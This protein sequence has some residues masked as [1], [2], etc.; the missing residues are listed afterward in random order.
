MAKSQLLAEKSTEND[1]F[2]KRIANIKL[3]SLLDI[4]KAINNNLST[5]RLF[6]LYE[7][8]LINELNIGKIALFTYNNNWK[9]VL[10]HGIENEF[11]DI[12]IEIDLL[13]YK[14]IT[15]IDVVAS[16]SA[17]METF[18]IIIPVYHKSQ[19]LAYLLIGDL[20]EQKI[21]MSPTIKHLPFVQTLTNIIMVAIENKRLARENLSQVASRK[22]LELAS[23][24]QA[25]L[26]P[27]KLPDDDNLNIH[28]YYQPHHQVG[29]DYY[30]FIKLNEN[31]VAFCVADVSGKGVSAALLMANF[32]ANLRA[33]FKHNSSLTEIIHDLNSLVF[34]NAKGEKFITIFLAKY[35]ILTRMLTYINAGHNPPLM[36]YS[37]TILQLTTGCIGVGMLP[38]IPRV[39]EGVKHVSADSV[40]VCYT[41]GL[42]EQNNEEGEDFGIEKLQQVMLKKQGIEM[43]KVNTNIILALDKFKQDV[44]YV[45]D[46]AL[47]SCKFL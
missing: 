15:E 29:G 9:C 30:D 1:N 36:L 37:N 23:E 4:T 14:E 42:V 12:K 6:K 39:R 19:A 40:L 11:E 7:N 21:E 35:N 34:D 17:S 28:A 8:I 18:D 10:K 45:D 38:E 2:R 33:L 16:N 44:T 24:M 41:D 26:F 43:K 46:I 32:Q 22:E 25:M 20:D 31:E 5:D 13:K 3:T 47:F 27:D